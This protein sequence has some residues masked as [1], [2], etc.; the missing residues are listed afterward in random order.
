[1][2]TTT[3]F[4]QPDLMKIVPAAQIRALLTQGPGDGFIEP[5]SQLWITGSLNLERMH[6]DTPLILRGC[7]LEKPVKLAGARLPA[8]EL[9]DG[10]TMPSLDAKHLVVDGDVRLDEI[11]C[12]SLDLS[13]A[14]V[15]DDL[16]LQHA[17]VEGP[18]NARGAQVS[19]RLIADHLTARGLHLTGASVHGQITL[20]CARLDV[21]RESREQRALDA[22]GLIAADGVEALGLATKG[23]VSFVDMQCTT[24]VELRGAQLENDVKG[25]PAL[26]LDR[27][28]VSG[29]LYCDEGFAAAGG[30]HAIGARID[31]SVY[32]DGA[33]L[34]NE[35]SNETALNLRRAKIGGDVNAGDRFTAK[36]IVDMASARIDGSL[37]LSG[38]HLANEV[39]GGEALILRCTTIAGNVEAGD[40]GTGCFTTEGCVDMDD[41]QI[42]GCVDYT[43][44]NLSAPN[45]TALTANRAR[46]GAGFLMD[47]IEVNGVLAL[48]SATIGC[49]L[50]I[51][52]P[53]IDAGWPERTALALES[54]S[55]CGK[56]RI[57]TDKDGD[58]I[59]G[60]VDLCRAEISTVELAGEPPSGTTDFTAA[61]L[62]L[63]RDEP[64][65]FLGLDRR[66]VL[67]GLTYKS[68]HLTDVAL[69]TRLAWLKAGTGKVRS[70]ANGYESPRHDCAPQPYEELAAAYRRLGLVKEARRILLEKNRA[71]TRGMHWRSEWH[72]RI[73]NRIQ[74]AL[75]G[76]GYAP[77]RAFLWVAA[78]FSIGVVYFGAIQNPVPTNGNGT[79]TG[80]DA[81]R[82]PMDLLLPA[83][84]IGGRSAWTPDR[85]FGTYLALT[86]MI[87]GWVLGF[88]IIAGIT[89]AM[90]RD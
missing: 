42:T 73:L 16:H 39:P 33:R 82:Y 78:L 38:A 31:G 25:K 29:S 18:L 70:S 45:G 1:M 53:Q 63:L 14:H 17:R 4:G 6:L 75:I 26:L 44:A 7:H 88:A 27:C 37:R 64:E 43:H 40:K 22:E 62:V 76:Y 59:R 65:K 32:L 34:V 61:R 50:L 2:V 21:D 66:L 58:Y 5:L 54:S 48:N 89:R 47:N 67:N 71:R 41:A 72:W 49:D 10:C 9:T 80:I 79:F 19:G 87:A 36:G 90:R 51:N 81:V 57:C 52:H 23:P 15:T 12:G 13:G 20:N 56:L 86:L 68:I 77:W 85:G 30:I 11:E 35:I 28:H 55:V 69:E 24:T 83:I 60:S 3:N 74:D 46:T 8:L 84:G